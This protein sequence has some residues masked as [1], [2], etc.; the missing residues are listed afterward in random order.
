MKPLKLTLSAFA[1]YAD[2]QEIDFTKLNGRNIFLVTGKTGAGKTTIFDAVSYA[3]YGSPSGDFRDV[4]SLRSDY[5]DGSVKTYVELEFELRGKIYKI[6]RNPEQMLNKKKGD[7]LKKELEAVEL[8]LPDGEKPLTRI[9][10][11]DERVKEILGVDKD[12]FHIILHII[13]ILHHSKPNE[14]TSFIV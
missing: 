10:D 14:S 1:N 8:Y 2:K 9:K 12:I 11:V 3:L 5:A 6:I 13:L 4:A 7:G